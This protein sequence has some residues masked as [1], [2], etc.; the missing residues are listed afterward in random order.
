MAITL[1]TNNALLKN[2][3]EDSLFV[4]REETV[5]TSL[6][7]VWNHSGYA[8]VEVGIWAQATAQEVGEGVD[9]A[10]P[11]TG[12]KTSKATFTPKEAMA[13]YLLT[14]R[15]VQTETPGNLQQAAAMEI[16]SAIAQKVDT[17]LLGNFSSFSSGAGSAGSAL[18]ITK[19]GVAIAL[20][21]NNNVRGQLS[22]VL[23]PYHWHDLWVEMGQPSANQ[24]FLGDVANQALRDSFVQRWNGINWYIS[25]NI[26]V[27]ASDDAYSAIF[28][29]DAMAFDLRE[30]FSI[31][32]ERDESLRAIEL[33][34]HIGYAEGILRNESGAYL[35]ADAATPS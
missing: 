12:A 10:N 2:I 27:D 24:A 33:N 6:V 13:Q 35:L 16:G 34:G 11:T 26:S 4:L 29:R 14:D 3:E 19:T 22:G 32:P 15:A 1:T 30:A 5:M 20:L 17:D 21:R 23:H 25:S 9:F 8:T 7:T 28:A 31:R 18:T